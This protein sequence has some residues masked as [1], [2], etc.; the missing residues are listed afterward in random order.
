MKKYLLC[1]LILSVMLFLFVGCGNSSKSTTSTD[2]NGTWK[3]YEM[4]DYEG[5]VFTGD[6]ISDEAFTIEGDHATNSIMGLEYEV[7][8]NDDGSYNFELLV[9]GEVKE[10]MGLEG[11]VFSGDVMTAEVMGNVYKY[12]KQ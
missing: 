11:V 9:R 10:G 7:R 2:I 5:N 1:V 8:A 3:L 12:K 6:D 4:T